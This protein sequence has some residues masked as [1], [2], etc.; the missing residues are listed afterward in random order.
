MVVV[1][2]WFSNAFSQS[3]QNKILNLNCILNRGQSEG[4]S[5]WSEKKKQAQEP[6]KGE[7][8]NL[9]HEHRLQF[10]KLWLSLFKKRA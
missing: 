7:L 6:G 5:V 1:D 10:V 9:P 8:S 2:R 3:N 4:C